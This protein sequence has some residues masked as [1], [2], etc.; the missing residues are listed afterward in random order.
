MGLEVDNRI[1]E[2]MYV[3]KANNHVAN[4]DE[5][6]NLKYNEAIPNI[7]KY[8][9]IIS[10]AYFLSKVES[11]ILYHITIRQRLVLNPNNLEILADLTY[12]TVATVTRIIK[13][14]E[15]RRFIYITNNK[16]IYLRAKFKVNLEKIFKTKFIIIEVNPNETSS[17]ISL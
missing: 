12:R 8:I 2:A 16:E 7:A 14:L 11:L 3:D 1:S 15:E 9:N 17:K 13:Q 10:A 5:I 4:K 6:I